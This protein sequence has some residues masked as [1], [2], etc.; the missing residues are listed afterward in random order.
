MKR[1]EKHQIQL[2]EINGLDNGRLYRAALAALIVLLTVNILYP[3][4]STD[5]S[6]K[7]G[8]ARI[9]PLGSVF[10]LTAPFIIIYAWNRRQLLSFSALDVL[11]LVTM[12]YVASRGILATT[13]VNGI[14]LTAGYA[15]YTLVLF[16][17]TAVIAQKRSAFKT[18]IITLVCLGSIAITL[19]LVEFFL[20]RNVL[21]SG[22]IKESVTP[23]VS[24]K[25]HRSGSTL[26]HPL[27]LGLFLTQVAPFFFIFYAKAASS[28]KK[29]VWGAA[30]IGLVLTLL[31]TFGKGPWGTALFIGSAAAI[32]LLW[33]K[34]QARKPVIMIIAAV[35]LSIT[36]FSIAFYENTSAGTFSKV[37]KSESIKPRSYMWSRA[38]TVIW[39][40]PLF[41]VG[42]WQAGPEVASVD[43]VDYGKYQPTA[44]DNQF[45]SVVVEQG[46]LGTLMITAT[47]FLLFRQA[48]Q[49]L[50][51][52]GIYSQWSAVLIISMGALIINGLTMD[53]LWMWSGMVVFW[54]TAG[55]LRGLYEMKQ[56]MIE[57]H[58]V[59]RTN[60]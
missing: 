30:I 23:I 4:T 10:V 27:A 50:K 15:A 52:G 45:I 54:L 25:Y 20:E 14:A 11:L 12:A 2:S 13:T 31:V 42:M 1:F 49:L 36:L 18:I 38:P 46:I 43:W 24:K 56:K 51:V 40:H 55:M 47:I 32:W 16:Y 34:P 58:D 9:S 60:Q 26:G 8:P 39:E 35:V 19:G 21:Y 48:L 59:F 44:I 41:G 6:W 17:G 22:I 28:V 33:K 57:P 29:I 5:L 7:L 37:R 3:D 53:S